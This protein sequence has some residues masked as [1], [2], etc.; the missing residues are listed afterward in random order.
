M[1]EKTIDLTGAKILVVDDVPNNLDVLCPLL[2]DVG[3]R[4]YVANNGATA[5]TLAEKL[6]PD[7]ILLDVMMPDMNG[8]EVC[9]HLKSE[10]KTRHIPV[11]FLSAQNDE[12]SLVT[13]FEAGGVDYVSK[14]FRKVE[15]LARIENHLTLARLKFDFE[16][17]VKKRGRELAREEVR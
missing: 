15:L 7:L 3:Y 9:E 2:E 5:L 4:L 8:Y 11:I 17:E 1:S 10:E 13:G 6:C 16:N 14:P 12:S